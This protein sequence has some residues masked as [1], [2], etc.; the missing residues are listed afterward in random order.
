MVDIPGDD[1]PDASGNVFTAKSKYE[2]EEFD[3]DSLGP[4]PP[5]PSEADYQSDVA[6]LFI[7]LVVVFN[8]AVLALALGPML[9]YFR[10]QT[11]LGIRVFL[12]GVITFSYGT[13]EYV[14]FK[15]RDDD[16]DASPDDEPPADAGTA[17]ETAPNGADHNG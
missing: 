11:D 12:L 15:R 8:I 3:P 2:P 10:G 1:D 13:F 5:E 9:V 4:A 7:K 6:G 14:K 16:E 17:S